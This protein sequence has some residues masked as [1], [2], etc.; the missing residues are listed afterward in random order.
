MHVPPS[1]YIMRRKTLKLAL[2]N[3]L[4]LGLIINNQLIFDCLRE[5]NLIDTYII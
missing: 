1:L 2:T 5:F 3:M 4:R